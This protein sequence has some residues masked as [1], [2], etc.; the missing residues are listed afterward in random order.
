MQVSHVDKIMVKQSSTVPICNLKGVLKPYFGLEASI[1]LRSSFKHI[2][3][4]R[5]AM[6]C[7]GL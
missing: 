4:G 7:Y 6:K 1:D 5:D 2:T 3:Y